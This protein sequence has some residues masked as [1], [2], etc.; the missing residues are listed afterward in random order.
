MGEFRRT[1]CYLGPDQ[2]D[3]KIDLSKLDIFNGDGEVRIFANVYDASAEAVLDDEEAYVAAV[4]ALMA[5]G[6]ERLAAMTAGLEGD[7]PTEVVWDRTGKEWLDD[8]HEDYDLIVMFGRRDKANYSLPSEWSLLRELERPLYVI[9][10]SKKKG[11]E[12]SAV[13]AAVD[14]ANA[15]Q[16]YLNG[17]V[18]DCAGRLAR[19]AGAALHMV[20]VIP[21]S[22]VVADLEFIDR[23]KYKASFRKKHG[24]A[25][26]DLARAH[27]VAEENIHTAIGVPHKVIQRTAKK[28]G[29]LATAV[30]TVQRKG[31]PGF[32]V[33]NTVEKVLGLSQRNILVVP[34]DD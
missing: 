16:S 13:L 7:W 3:G 31:V 1:L 5:R 32:I 19:Q 12:G 14:I 29:V 27:G 4:K 20:A 34:E 24:P 9:S 28:L 33:G 17:K 2:L 26:T 11:G 30:G 6:H 25:L 18:M 15:S 21:M 10:P 23:R 22:D 8:H